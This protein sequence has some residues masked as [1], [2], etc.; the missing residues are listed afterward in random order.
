[1]KTTER[2]PD[3]AEK[4]NIY[5]SLHDVSTIDELSNK[6]DTAAIFRLYGVSYANR[7]WSSSP[8]S[9]YGK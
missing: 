9:S 4:L 5:S 3:I 2:E 1:M 7:K 8:F 6:D